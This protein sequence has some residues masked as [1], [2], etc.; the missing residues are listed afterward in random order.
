MMTRKK[1]RLYMLLLALV[2]L[3]TATALTL[4]AFEENVAFF[5]SPSDLT[6]KP[7]GD[8]RVRVGGLVRLGR[9][10][11]PLAPPRPLAAARHGTPA[12]T[13]RAAGSAGLATAPVRRS[14][15]VDAQT[16]PLFPEEKGPD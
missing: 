8:K 13:D 15:A 16:L 7:P 11:L 10:G 9:D 1:R 2:G 5:F 3:G 12:G 4:T 6:V 14:V